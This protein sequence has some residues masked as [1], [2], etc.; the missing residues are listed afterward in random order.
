MKI[1]ISPL[2]VGGPE[3]RSLCDTARRAESL[4]FE[5]VWTFEHVIVPMDYA[6]PYPYSRSGKMPIAPDAHFVDPLIALAQAA[7]V[8]TTIKLATGINILPQTNPLLLA[9]QAASLD[10]CS[11][12]RLLLGI[13][14]GWLREEFD[15]MGVPF[16]RR[17][18]RMNDYIDAMRKVWSGEVVEHQGEFVQWSGFKSYPL[19]HGH[20]PLHIGGA[21]KAAMRRAAKRGDGWF[22]PNH[23]LKDLEESLTEFRAVC[24]QQGRDPSTVE[25]TAMW[26]AGRHPDVLPAYRDF[27]VDR[28]VVN[29]FLL[30]APDSATAMERLAAAVDK[31]GISS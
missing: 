25:I 31:A 4:G 30:G 2:N 17:G 5:S 15:A 28:V 14:A 3:V 16:E 18:A 12:G 7:A 27:G 29:L 19:P 22:V 9:K 21:S 1:G 8:T 23:G 10:F 13:G 11:N 26:N 24:D 6:S 20:L